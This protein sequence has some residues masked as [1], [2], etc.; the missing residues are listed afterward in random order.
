MAGGG[1]WPLSRVRHT[2]QVLARHAGTEG[3]R[4]SWWRMMTLTPDN[5]VP[6]AARRLVTAIFVAAVMI[7][8]FIMSGL[9]GAVLGT[10]VFAAGAWLFHLVSHG[11]RWRQPGPSTLSLLA[12]RTPERVASLHRIGAVTVVTC[13][14]VGIVCLVAMRS[15]PSMWP[16][17]ILTLALGQTLTAPRD[18][19]Q[20]TSPR[21]TLADD[22][23][24]ALVRG[25]LAGPPGGV[26]VGLVFLA[27][28]RASAAM[29]LAGTCCLVGFFI[30]ASGTAWCQFAI[31]RVWLATHGVLPW[32]MMTFLDDAQR[33]G[34]LRPVGASY[35]F[36]YP[37]LQR[38]LAAD[39]AGPD[40]D[41]ARLPAGVPTAATP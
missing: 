21:A 29:V 19:E 33:W 41:G 2:L 31:A 9:I 14:S 35:E 32:R 1:R 23:M 4:I 30:G 12:R 24:L 6:R 38:R 22:R 15:L 7:V 17:L 16:M 37:T 3:G 39:A 13:L 18:L 36:R 34:L 28:G 20:A 10:L 8:M 27:L 5:F 40:R 25:L 26:L 11:W